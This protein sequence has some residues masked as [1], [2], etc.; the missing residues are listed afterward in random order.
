MIACRGQIWIENRSGNLFI[1][2]KVMRWPSN[3]MKDLIEVD[4]PGVKISF[5][6]AYYFY[7]L[8]TYIGRL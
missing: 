4:S 7:E 2:T 5:T 6:W 3:R 8:F 1:V